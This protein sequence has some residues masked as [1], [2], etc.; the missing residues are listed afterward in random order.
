MAS[1]KPVDKEDLCSLIL[2][3]HVDTR[4]DLFYS[5]SGV[6]KNNHA[7]YPKII[8]SECAPLIKQNQI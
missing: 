5:L 1:H 6:G 2:K 8:Q 4:L 3:L 7:G